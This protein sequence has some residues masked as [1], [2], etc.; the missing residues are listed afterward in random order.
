MARRCALL[1]AAAAPTAL[2]Y[3]HGFAP[4]STSDQPFVCEYRKLALE[5]AKQVQPQHDAALTF[6]ALMLGSLCN[7][8]RPSEEA[9]PALGAAERRPEA[10]CSV[11]VAT[12]G[13]DSHAGTSAATAKKTVAAGVE[14][15]RKLSGPK[16]LCVGVGTFHLDAPLALT[17]ADSGLTIQG[18]TPNAGRDGRTWIS[19]AQALTKLKWEQYKV[20]PA[21]KGTLDA[22]ANTDNQHG[23]TPSDPSPIATGGCGCYPNSD[24]AEAC[25]ARCE[26]MGE[27]ACKSYAWSGAAGGPW[28]NQCCIHADDVWHP[29]TGTGSDK[30]HTAG[31]W[32]GGSPAKNIW[33]AVLPAGINLPTAPQLRIGGV[34]SSRARFPNSMPETEYWPAG[35]VPNAQTWLPAKP[36][37]SQP[38]FVHVL[39]KEIQ[40]RNDGDTINQSKPYSGGIGGP[41]EVFDPPCAA[42][43]LLCSG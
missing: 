29:Q 37:S 34:R 39:N 9:A 27:A 18:E 31:H 14:A 15:T 6:D 20:T 4:D 7:E 22:E 21:V 33:K 25:R 41:C 26:A 35:W 36:P 40:S 17:A 30:N 24:S 5:F 11:F 16:V 13:D 28:G 19:G 43:P 32:T 8:T 12:T 38:Q 10:D 1:L 2:G 23:C 42:L 3:G